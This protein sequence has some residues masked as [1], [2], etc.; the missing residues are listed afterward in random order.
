[1][2]QHSELNKRQLGTVDVELQRLIPH[3]IEAIVFDGPRLLV[4]VTICLHPEHLDFYERIALF[5]LES[6]TADD[7]QM[8]HLLALHGGRLRRIELGILE[9]TGL[10]HKAT[11]PIIREHGSVQVHRCVLCLEVQSHFFRNLTFF[12]LSNEPL[13]TAGAYRPCINLGVCP[14]K[15]FFFAQIKNYFFR[16]ML[17]F[18]SLRAFISND[19]FCI[20]INNVCF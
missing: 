18:F 14:S 1:M 20:Y 12:V 16:F 9:H 10:E 2:V 7:L 11:A 6:L 13:R 3:G 19:I 15:Y 5:A 17:I 8:E 4:L